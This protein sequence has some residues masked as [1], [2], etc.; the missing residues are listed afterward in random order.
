ML[1]RRAVLGLLAVP[2]L[3]V[4]TRAG[5][6]AEPTGKVIL[7]VSGKI[8]IRNSPAEA[9]FDLAMLDAL[10]QGRFEGETPWT[11]GTTVFTGP[12]G[13][14]LLDAVGASGTTMQVNAL[15]DYNAD[16][17]VSDF[18]EHAV[19]LATRHDGELMSI[20]NRGPIWVIYPM[21][22]EPSLRVETTYTRSVWQVKSI[23]V[24]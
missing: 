1:Y 11:H 24:R 16:I 9:Q 7:S 6:L 8:A 22:K 3:A 10:P 12:L 15:N 2:I 4:V 23:D 5:T 18:R 14:A 21:D 13:A 20:R 17:P 19:I